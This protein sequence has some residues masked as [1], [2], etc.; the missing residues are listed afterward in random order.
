MAHSLQLMQCLCVSKLNL[1][2][3]IGTSL[4]RRTERCNILFSKFELRNEG[5][6]LSTSAAYTQV[7]TVLI[8][9]ALMRANLKLQ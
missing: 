1:F 9:L 6:G 5:C 8:I 2:I 7:F 4:G 3:S